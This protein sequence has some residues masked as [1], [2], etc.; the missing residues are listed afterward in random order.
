MSIFQWRLDEFSQKYITLYLYIGFFRKPEKLG[1]HIGS[2]WWP[3]DPDVKDD[4]N[5]PLTQWPNDPVPCLVHITSHA[6]VNSGT[7][8]CVKK[9]T[10]SWRRARAAIVCRRGRWC[11]T[12][13]RSRPG[14]MSD[15]RRST[16]AAASTAN[17]ATRR[18][19]RY[20]VNS[21]LLRIV[22][23]QNGLFSFLC[24]RARKRADTIV[25][26][27]VPWAGHFQG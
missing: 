26:V 24:N 2:K 23:R 22:A 17:T 6:C 27:R 1:S 14:P 13:Y 20:L 11:R 3:G 9:P 19:G 15:D 7:Y 25:T 10:R 16:P 4:P 8:N 5:D 18:H 21:Q 12:R